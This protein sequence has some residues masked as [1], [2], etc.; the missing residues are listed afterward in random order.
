M[1]KKTHPTLFLKMLT[2]TWACWK[3]G[4]NTPAQ[5]SQFVKK[6][7]KQS[8]IKELCLCSLDSGLVVSSL[9]P[10]EGCQK[11]Y[12]WLIRTF[13]RWPHQSRCSSLLAGTERPCYFLIE[14]SHKGLSL[15]FTPAGGRA[16]I[17]SQSLESDSYTLSE[18]QLISGQDWAAEVPAERCAILSTKTSSEKKAKCIQI[19]KHFKS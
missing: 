1:G 18:D 7:T 10:G 17:C 11:I 8:T 4:I 3:N 14:F 6:A 12:E 9:I 15:Q 16:D 19:F 2:I 5:H 13:S